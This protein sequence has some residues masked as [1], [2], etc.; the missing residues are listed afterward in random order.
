MKIAICAATPFQSLN[1]VNLAM[2]SLN[3]ND[4]KVLFYRNYS[5]T[6][7]KIL[8]G[9]LKYSIFD[10]IYEY[11]LVKKD[12]KILYLFNDLIQAIN[13]RLFLKWITKKHI[14]VSNKKFDVIT[15]TSGT[16]FEVALTRV[17]PHAKTIAYDDGIGSYVGDIIH[18]N[19]LKWIWKVLG[20]RTD[21]INP[22]ILFVNNVEVC[23]S[24]LSKK[25]KQLTSLNS[26][27][28]KDKKI[29][30][31]IF[32]MDNIDIYLSRR[33]IY[34]SQ[35]IDELGQNLE[36]IKRE[37]ESSLL[38][39]K[40][41]GIYRKHPRD[42]QEAKVEFVAD[43]SD[44]L[45]ELICGEVINDNNI[46]VS[47]C[48]S[49]Q[50]MPKILYDKEPWIIFTYRLFD[51]ENTDIYVN[52][53]KPIIEIIKRKYREPNKIVEPKSVKELKYAIT[54]IME[55]NKIREIRNDS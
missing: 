41:E 44:C 30:K 5:S 31:N 28:K 52:R 51:L 2:H 54:K 24:T 19:E 42:S 1:A 8:K 3:N 16:E 22:D 9:I 34:L 10:E 12:N 48:S 38:V 50:I 55:F 37:I 46:L 15:V 7:D 25:I 33:L 21:Y 47:L 14:D 43:Q 6:T 23:E 40:N 35:P 29:L 18:D 53:F 17:F 39:F 26:M 49:S 13:P 4:I 27:N 45:W 36:K 32:C 11:D 20:R